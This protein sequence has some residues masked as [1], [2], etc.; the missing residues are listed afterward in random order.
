MNHLRVFGSTAYVH[1]PKDERGKLD[2]KTKK[3]ALLG[4]GN[5]QK[6]YRVYDPVSKKT[7][8][9]EMSSLMSMRRKQLKLRRRAQVSVR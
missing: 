2:S 6:G 1:I 5:V 7:L 9:A 3:C 8:T 4:Y